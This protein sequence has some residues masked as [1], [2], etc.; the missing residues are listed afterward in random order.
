MA[1]S[2]D[3]PTLSVV[4]P[5]YNEAENLAPLLARLRS[6]LENRWNDYEIL[7]VDDGSTDLTASHIGHAQRDDP[8]ILLVQLSRNFGH[9]AAL[10]AGLTAA[11]GQVV[12]T[13]DGD[14]QHPPE[15]IAT[16][17]D[18]WREGYE[19]V[20]TVR[21]E[22]ADESRMKRAGS[23]GFYRLLSAL[24]RLD[25]TPGATDFR[26]MA[27]PAVDAFLAC[28]ERC[29]FNRGLVQWIGFRRCEIPYQA[30]PRYAGRSK[31]SVRTLVRLAGDAL[32]SFS[33]WP[34]RL[35][36]CLGA[37]LSIPAGIYLIFVIWARLFTDRAQPGW[38]SILATVLILGGVNL[39][40]LWI[41][42]E[43]VG[44]M[45]DEV[46]RRP[47]FIV[48][49]ES[50]P[51]ESAPPPSAGEESAQGRQNVTDRGPSAA[52]REGT[53]R[54]LSVQPRKD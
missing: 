33:S 2:V 14:L 54:E 12:V 26:L 43:Y 19:I 8:R 47:I 7:L 45:Y 37:L 34:L 50:A 3:S 20:Q 16:L 42:G 32:F 36:G 4:V 13:L 23:R 9:Q 44:R 38:G 18:R 30:E 48:R 21:R 51:P 24:T 46:K 29:R 49:P 10:V 1:F 17:I 53:G 25:L 15:L 28:E 11:R 40:V 39:I 5:V 35:A 22:P 31:Y 6:T 27:R 52:K 41:L